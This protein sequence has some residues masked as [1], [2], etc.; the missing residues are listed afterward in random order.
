MFDQKC[1]FCFVGQHR[2]HDFHTVQTVFSIL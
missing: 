2:H 1:S